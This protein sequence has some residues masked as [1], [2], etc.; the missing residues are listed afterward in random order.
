MIL[1]NLVPGIDIPGDTSKPRH[2]PGIDILATSSKPRHV[3]EP[4]TILGPAQQADKQS[5]YLYR[6]I[7]KKVIS[8]TF[9]LLRHLFSVILKLIFHNKCY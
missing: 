3:P 9:R 6:L 2:V 8:K 4:P 1:L 5:T 7:E